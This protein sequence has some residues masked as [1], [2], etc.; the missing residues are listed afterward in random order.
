MKVARTRL[1]LY[2]NLYWA[3]QGL[4]HAVRAL[5]EAEMPFLSAAPSELLKFNLHRAQAM[6]EETRVLMNEILGE[7][8]EGK[9]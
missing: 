3:N 1:D 7:W 5:Q 2:R 8:V 9:E 6:I 4:L